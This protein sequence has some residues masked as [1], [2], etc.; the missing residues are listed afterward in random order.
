MI[1]CGVTVLICGQNA[2]RTD[3]SE[4]L[5]IWAPTLEL[6]ELLGRMDPALTAS[7]IEPGL[8]VRQAEIFSGDKEIA[9]VDITKAESPHDSP[10]R[11]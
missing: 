8:K 7:V 9:S 3:K 1:R 10:K 4:A 5:V 6:L 2:Q 11:D